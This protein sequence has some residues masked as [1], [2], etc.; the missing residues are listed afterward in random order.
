LIDFIISLAKWLGNWSA[1]MGDVV[2]IATGLT[3]KDVGTVTPLRKHGRDGR[4]VTVQAFDYRRDLVKVALSLSPCFKTPLRGYTNF[5]GVS[6]VVIP[7]ALFM[8]SESAVFHQHCNGVCHK[9]LTV[10]F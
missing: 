8:S 7:T 1:I 9:V 5:T 6:I 4:A 10:K 2:R 3:A